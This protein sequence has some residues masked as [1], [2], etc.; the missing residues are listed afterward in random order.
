MFGVP[1][2]AVSLGHFGPFFKSAK[3]DRHGRSHLYI[4][5]ALRRL[6][7]EECR[8]FQDGALPLTAFQFLR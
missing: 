1:S 8:E 7:Q 2:E 3:P 5:V 6:I 4:I